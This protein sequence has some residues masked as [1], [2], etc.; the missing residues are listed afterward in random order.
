[1]PSFFLKEL[2]ENSF[3]THDISKN[4]MTIW[5]NSRQG[6]IGKSFAKF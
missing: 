4:W 2:N 6:N 1:M 5:V 3:I